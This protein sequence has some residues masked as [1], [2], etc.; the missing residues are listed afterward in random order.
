MEFIKNYSD[1][2]TE[3][4]MTQHGDQRV[5]ERIASLENIELIPAQSK[6]IRA[7]G[8]QPADIKQQIVDQIKIAFNKRLE[9]ILRIDFPAGA[10][11]VP[12]I[13]AQLY[14]D[15]ISD[16]IRLFVTSGVYKW[17]KDGKQT[18]VADKT[19]PGEKV[20]F[21]IIDNNI[22]T[23]LVY[24]YMFSDREIQDKVTDH[25]T[26]KGNDKPVRV[27]PLTDD[28][29]LKLEIV[30]GEVV[31]MQ[32]KNS[33]FVDYT[34]DQQWAIA[35]GRKMMVYIPFAKDFVEATIEKLENPELSMNQSK[36]PKW[37]EREFQIAVTIQH[38]GKPMKIKK[39]LWIDDV[40]FLPI[41]E[42]EEMV[43]CKIVAPGSVFD[44]RAKNPMNIKFR[45]VK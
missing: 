10:R 42:N 25:F 38:N 17:T 43:R 24:D 28:M 23:V 31:P 4:Y 40:I 16:F 21:S 39:K 8:L 6:A 22:A 5:G 27:S 35:P 34:V 44:S 12:V 33:S 13:A 41:G 19:Y 1:Y 15:G 37:K 18:K 9:E 30:D 11:V 2:I 36:E 45:A 32:K 7:M 20:Y 26:R 29:I 3:A 14:I